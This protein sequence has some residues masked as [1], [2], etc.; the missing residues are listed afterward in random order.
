MP[1]EKTL[2]DISFSSLLIKISV[3]KIDTFSLISFFILYYIFQ[4]MRKKNLIN[5][6]IIIFIQK[7]DFVF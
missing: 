5:H 1:I 4:D 3:S 6:E 2:I 7:I